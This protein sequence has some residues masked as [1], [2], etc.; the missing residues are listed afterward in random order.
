MDSAT[1]VYDDIFIFI[2][3]AQLLIVGLDTHERSTCT[4][5]QLDSS[6][7]S[8]VDSINMSLGNLFFLS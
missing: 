4:E 7:D 3:Q 2:L 5:D 1:I 6:L 8:L